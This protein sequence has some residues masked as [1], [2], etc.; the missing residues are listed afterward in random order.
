MLVRR[1]EEGCLRNDF[2]LSLG[3][4]ED[5]PSLWHYNLPHKP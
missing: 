2:K 5:T 3:K 4:G 1:V